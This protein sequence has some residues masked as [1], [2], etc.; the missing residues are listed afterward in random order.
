MRSLL[1]AALAS[2]V[3]V[4]L[5]LTGCSNSDP[6]SAGEEVDEL[7]VGTTE[8][9]PNLTPGRQTNAFGLT[10]SIFSPLTFLDG[11]GELSYLAAES[12]ESDNQIDW[13]ITLQDDWTF[14][15]GTPVT[16]Q[17]YVDTWNTVAYGPNAFENSGQLSIIDGYSELNP[18]EGEPTTDT[19]AGL[20]VVDEHTFTVTLERADSQ[21]PIEL[22]QAQTA[23]YPMP[24]SAYDDLEAYG[25]QPIGNGPLA[26][27]APWVEGQPIVAEAYENYAGEASTVDKITWVP[28]SD[29]LTAYTDALAG[30]VDI[31][32]LPATRMNQVADDFEEDNI[33]SFSAP[34][35]SFL[36]IPFWDER[37][38]DIRVRQA[39]SMAID[40]NAINEAIFGNFYEPATA[41]TPSIM[42]GTPEGI[43]GEYCEYDPEA[44]AALLEEA[45][46]F[47]GQ[48][49]LH[50]PGAAGHDD[51]YNA[52]AN[53]LRQNLGIDAIAKPAVGW[54]EFI[55]D[56]N[57]EVID[58]PFFTRWGALYPSQQSTL[59]ALFSS[60][61]SCTNCGGAFNPDVETAL[62]EADEFGSEDG[63]AY[64]AAQ[65]LL[66]ADFPIIPLFEESYNYVTSDRIAEVTASAV[67]EPILTQ[68]ILADK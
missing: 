50:F 16:A 2:T 60:A 19:L 29:R 36:G 67:G 46:G 57:T 35:I 42:P 24:Q 26:L 40:R 21:F 31:T 59:R 63:A 53:Y 48:L 68:I 45:G 8:P 12:V 58:G 9:V 54:A 64:A 30:N 7:V 33:H 61:P 55:Q 13:T 4:A 51:L 22:S 6:D 43:C 56:R 23:F 34:G 25:K 17:D 66:A 20:T 15:D 47:E 62:N 27:T 32:W 14:H 10:L 5:A 1:K 41:W 37:F 65:E 44:A 39:I 49:T 11:N 52:L 38:E 3:V 18:A 28:Y